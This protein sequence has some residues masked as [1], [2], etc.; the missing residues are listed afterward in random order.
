MPYKIVDIKENNLVDSLNKEENDGWNPVQW[1]GTHQ[2]ISHQFHTR[3]L[4][5]KIPVVKNGKK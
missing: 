1:L 5:Y 4:F 2:D 3:I